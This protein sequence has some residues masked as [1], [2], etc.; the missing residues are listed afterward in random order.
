MEKII[1]NGYLY[2]I[3]VYALIAVMIVIRKLVNKEGVKA[4]LFSFDKRGF[5]YLAG[6]FLSGL[7]IMGGYLLAAWAVGG[8]RLDLL[9]GQALNDLRVLGVSAFMFAAVAVFEEFLYR[10]YLLPVLQ[11]RLGTLWAVLIPSAIFG[12]WHFTAY[13]QDLYFFIGLLNAF[14]FAVGSALVVL[15]IKSTMFGIGLHFIYDVTQGLIYSHINLGLLTSVNVF[16]KESSLAGSP[17]N[18]ESGWLMTAAYLVFFA[19]LIPLLHRQRKAH[20]GKA[21]ASI[22]GLAWR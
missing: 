8:V 6:G 11:R 17:V 22:G 9:P 7:V 4:F 15:T 19:V 12:L 3:F 20:S 21:E 13:S 16:T 1:L 5:A 10:G 18:P 2:G 14:I